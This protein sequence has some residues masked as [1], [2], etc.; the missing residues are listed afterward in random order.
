[1]K[2]WGSEQGRE[3]KQPIK[4]MSSSKFTLWAAGTDA[5]QAAPGAS[6]EQYPRVV[7]TRC[8]GA[9]LVFTPLPR[10]HWLRATPWGC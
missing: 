6:M 2:E 5:S 7:P 10:A 4:G 1:M 3:G 8:E 9:G